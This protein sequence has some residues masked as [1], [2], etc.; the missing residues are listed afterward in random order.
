MNNVTING[1]DFEK[2]GSTPL[3]LNNGGLVLH[4]NRAGNVMGAY[5]VTSFRDGKG[6]YHGDQ[7]SPYCSLVNLDNGYIAFDERCSRATTMVR[8]LSHLSPND[9]A[10]KKAVE[11]GQYLE[12]YPVGSFKI[13]LALNKGEL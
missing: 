3:K 5:L 4:Y 13:D 7:T 2:L 9:Y 11:E 8:V 6:K 10:G 1:K 12:V